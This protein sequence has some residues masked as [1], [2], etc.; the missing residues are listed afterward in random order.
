MKKHTFRIAVQLRGKRIG[1]YLA[2]GI[3]VFG[4]SNIA[5]VQ[6]ANAQVYSVLNWMVDTNM[7]VAP[8]TV[9]NA[10]QTTTFVNGTNPAVR[11]YQ[12]FANSTI[13]DT[14][15]TVSLAYVGDQIT[16][17]GTAIFTGGGSGT[18]YDYGNVQWRIGLFYKGDR[19]PPPEIHGTNWLGYFIGAGSGTTTS[20]LYER[21]DP[22]TGMYA[23][24]T[25]ATINWTGA[26]PGSGINHSPG[27]YN[28]LLNIERDDVNQLRFN[29]SIIGTNALGQLYSVSGTDLLDTTPTTMAFDRVGMLCGAS[30]S[31]LQIRY[32]NVEVIYRPV[33]EP[34]ALALGAIGL[35]AVALWRWRSKRERS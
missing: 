16:L 32:D 18:A 26:G 25:G 4:L 35:A 12:F 34:S 7:Q 20:P 14:P 11:L 21:A 13:G 28:F 33:P 6:L 24:G 22:N 27:T 31:A 8:V 15:T 1:L 23:S 17:R 29:F 5:C 30:L 10:Y 2:V 3:V 9:V 19:N